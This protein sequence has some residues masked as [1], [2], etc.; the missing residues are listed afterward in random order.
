MN[1][2][3]PIADLSRFQRGPVVQRHREVGTRESF[4][5]SI[6]EHPLG[7]AHDLFRRL[8]DQHHRAAPLRF[9]IGQHLR[10]AEERGHVDVVSA[11]VHH[12]RVLAGVREPRLL[13]D[14]QAVHVAAHQHHG[15]LPLRRM[16]TTP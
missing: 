16:A 9:Q 14:R 5:Q 2:S 11:R 7:A 15:P 13:G 6:G 4:V 3:G 10:R 12:A 1:G 8:P